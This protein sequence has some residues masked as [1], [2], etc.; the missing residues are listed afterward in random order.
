M[1][2]QI[3]IAL[4]LCSLAGCLS[5][6]YSVRVPVALG[7]VVVLNVLIEMIDMPLEANHPLRVASAALVMA[8]AYSEMSRTNW[9]WSRVPRAWLMAIATFALAGVDI[10]A[11]FFYVLGEPWI[12]PGFAITTCLFICAVALVPEGRFTWLES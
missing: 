5:C 7:S 6:W 8:L 1:T 12:V 11:I 9:H 10:A 2:A 4:V 3:V